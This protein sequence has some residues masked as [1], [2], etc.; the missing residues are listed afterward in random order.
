MH[1]AVPQSPEECAVDILRA[2]RM[3]VPIKKFGTKRIRME[4]WDSVAIT[5]ANIGFCW[6]CAAQVK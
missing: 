3:L 5:G 6:L 2:T 4:E 1:S